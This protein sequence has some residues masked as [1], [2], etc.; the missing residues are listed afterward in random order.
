MG[1]FVE[2]PTPDTIDIRTGNKT[3][4]AL[5]YDDFQP[6][7]LMAEMKSLHIGSRFAFCLAAVYLNLHSDE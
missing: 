2:F 5:S 3:F 1:N 6:R 4:A 7:A